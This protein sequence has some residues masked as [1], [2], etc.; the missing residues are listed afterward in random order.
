MQE[1]RRRRAISTNHCLVRQLPGLDYTE[2]SIEIAVAAGDDRSKVILR[3]YAGR[4]PG[5]E[6]L[7]VIELGG[8][9]T[10]I[11]E[12]KTIFLLMIDKWTE[13]LKLFECARNKT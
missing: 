4:A 5:L 13:M 12:V 1:G 6:D 11:R 2:P 8:P 9:S 3:A 7:L 10:I